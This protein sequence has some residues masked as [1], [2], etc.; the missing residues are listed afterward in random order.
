MH[1]ACVPFGGVHIVL[2]GDF[3]QLP[4]VRA[5]S[6]YLDP[7]YK[8]RPS[9]VGVQGFEL[10]RQVTTIVM[11]DESRE[12]PA[13]VATAKGI[14]NGTLGRLE[15]VHFPADTEFR[16][17]RD[18]ATSMI[19]RLPSR[20]PEYAVIRV[21]RPQAVAVRPGGDPDRFPV[22][23]NTKAKAKTTIRLAPAP[24]GQPRAVTVRPQQFPFACAVGSTV[25]IVQGETLRSMVVVDGRD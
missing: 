1:V 9:T 12:R 25:Y 5:G 11:L 18:A 21:P 19:V 17:V 20:A 2:V 15:Y 22:L 4:P 3:L 23:F 14:T 10:W 13:Y 6:I 24:D 8:A 7:M 16:L